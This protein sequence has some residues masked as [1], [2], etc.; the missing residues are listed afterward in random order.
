MS[1]APQP[2]SANFPIVGEDFK[3]TPYFIRWAQERQIDIQNSASPGEIDDA[4]NNWSSARSINTPGGGGLTG[5]GNLSSDLTLGIANTSVTPG[6]YSCPNI[7]VNSQGR[8]TSATTVDPTG[9]LQIPTLSLGWIGYGSGY[10]SP[11]Y[12]KDRHGRVTVEG[13]M[14]SGTDGV[15][16][17]F[18][19]G[20]RPDGTLMFICWSG[21]G[22]YRVDVRATG[23]LEVFGS[24]A[25]FSS[26]TGISFFAV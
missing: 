9:S 15:V 4:I 23:E 18:L 1:K 2:L 19:P 10:V 12:R 6:S 17:T 22:P 3:P 11:R 25:V 5:G 26:L 16:F 24:N 7:T 20:F 14:Q 8:I 21:G 13:L